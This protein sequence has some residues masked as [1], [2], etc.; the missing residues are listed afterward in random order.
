MTSMVMGITEFRD[1]SFGLSLENHE[2]LDAA[3]N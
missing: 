3:P 1:P 2:E